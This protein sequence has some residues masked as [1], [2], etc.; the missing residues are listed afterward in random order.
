MAKQAH[1]PELKF[2]RVYFAKGDMPKSR[3]RY[4][5]S[6]PP[7]TGHS[8]VFV[9]AGEKRSTIFCL[10]TFRSYQVR[11]DCA[12]I[13]LAEPWAMPDDIVSRIQHTWAKWHAMGAQVDYDV[14]AV[15]LTRL[16]GE[17][18]KLAAIERPGQEPKESRG[19]KALDETLLRPVKRT[20]KR[21]QVLEFFMGEGAQSI[22]EAMARMDLTRSGVLSHLF[23]LNRDHG[24]GYELAG[25]VV[26]L[27]LPEGY[28]PFH[29]PEPTV[30]DEPGEPKAEK[31][32]RRQSG[33]K[34]IVTEALKPIARP[35]KR[36]E[37]ADIFL[38]GYAS[39]DDAAAKLEITRS[40]VL[41]HLFTIN[42][43]NGL[44]YAVSEDGQ[45]A[46]LLVP[47]GHVVFGE[48]QPRKK[49][50]AQDA[51]QPTKQEAPAV[52]DDDDWLK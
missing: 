5:L 32:Q 17:V 25:D 52:E 31:P 28:D 36:A 26:R 2:M 6:D 15:V 48:K 30:S 51:P 8:R 45:Q 50:E 33:G 12:E 16:G 42:R 3:H 14:A 19:G 11:N 43:E 44:G 13:E 34:P 22:L 49:K 4:A 18:P 27:G 37:I 41:S 29:F 40:G 21:G 10:H 24:I 9:L 1:E 7:C 38:E 46:K 20:S 47:E 35:S 39:L 23:C